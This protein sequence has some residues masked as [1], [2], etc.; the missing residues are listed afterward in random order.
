VAIDM[1]LAYINAVS[2]HLPKAVIVFD[3]FHI[4]KLYN[5]PGKGD[6]SNFHSGTG[7]SRPPAGVERKL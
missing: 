5:G 2:T 1:S 4:I 7:L 6:K 3:H